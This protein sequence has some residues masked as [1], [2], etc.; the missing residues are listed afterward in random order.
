[1][2]RKDVAARSPLRVF[3]RS[4]HGGLGPGNLG[5][6]LAQ[7][8]VGKTAFLAQIGLE[9]LL[10]ERKV[11]H[12]S[13]STTVAEVRQCYDALV[14]D[15]RE[16]GAFSDPVAAALVIERNRMIQVY[17]E[18]S[19]SSERLR[20][21]TEMLAEHADFVPTTILVDGGDWSLMAPT[22]VEEFKDLALSVGAELWMTALTTR[23]VRTGDNEVLPPPADRFDALI[24]VAVHLSPRGQHVDLRLLRDHDSSDVAATTLELEP[25]TMRLTDSSPAGPV[26]SC[27]P[28][29]SDCTIY[30]GG[31]EGAEAAF[32]AQAE[33][34]GMAEVNFSFG[35][36]DITRARGLTELS[37]SDLRRGDVSLAYVSKRM[38]R[39]YSV[40]PEFRRI[41]Q[42][43]WHQVNHAGQVLV[44]GALLEDGT[45]RGGT[46]W[47][48]ELA[49]VWNKP[50]W[51]F[52]QEREAWFHWV[53]L[54]QKWVPSETPALRA[55]GICGTG[56]RS[57]S[58]AGR[59]AIE[60]VFEHSFSQ[61]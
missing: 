41:L 51:V 50:L 3:E 38:G 27:R 8:G 15:L 46:G 17:P 9:D 14:L 58:S 34:F 2:Y 57:L 37:E 6:I 35:G 29:T 52:D 56:T 53:V 23:H 61:D 36:R 42:S 25:F 11:L 43:I 55:G 31:A 4:I 47:G 12:V 39:T 26:G 44:V 60:S 30:S 40:A 48:A 54:D 28:R 5:V 10:Q 33:R 59:A 24:D 13:T 7:A 16:T 45:V 49:R 20:R 22:E 32:G 19:M 21:V 18:H 1:M